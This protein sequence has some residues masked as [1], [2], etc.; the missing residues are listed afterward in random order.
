MF[1]II[2]IVIKINDSL[3]DKTSAKID[4]F[5]T[6]QGIRVIYDFSEIKEKAE[7]VIIV[8]GDGT[9]LKAARTFVDYNIPILGINCGRLG[10][11]A[12]LNAD[13]AVDIIRE[14]LEGSYMKE[15]RLMLSCAAEK[16][17]KNIY[18]HLALNDAVIHRN[19]IPKML[20]FDV[21]VDGDLINTQRADGIIVS[22]PTGSTAYTL[23]SGGPI[24]HPSLEVLIL[25]SICPHT[26]SHRPIVIHA[27]SEVVIN[28]IDSYDRATIAFDA[29]ATPKNVVA[30]SVIIKRHKNKVHLIHPKSYNYFSIINSKLRWQIKI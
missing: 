18:E 25:V 11:L 9:I 10:F 3:S 17:G 21:Y 6:N 22:T 26:M 30:D 24:V 27:D 28:I 20:L 2:G 14:I 29:Q 5:L 16:D 19:Y 12:D 15:S 13:K 1:N 8:G 23:S 7:L 4:N